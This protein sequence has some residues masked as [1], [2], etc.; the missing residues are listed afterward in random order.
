MLHFIFISDLIIIVLTSYVIALMRMRTLSTRNMS[1]P[2][3]NTTEAQATEAAPTDNKE[4]QANEADTETTSQTPK[5]GRRTFVAPEG[6]P[7]RPVMPDYASLP[8][9]KRAEAKKAYKKELRAWRRSCKK[10]N[11]A[12]EAQAEPVS[13]PVTTTE[14]APEATEP[15][16]VPQAEP[17]KKLTDEEKKARRRERRAARKAAKEAEQASQATP[18][19]PKTEPKT[20]PVTNHSAQEAAPSE[21]EQKEEPKADSPMKKSDYISAIITKM[22]NG[23]HLASNI[24][25]TMGKAA[26]TITGTDIV[27]N[28][29]VFVVSDGKE[30]KEVKAQTVCFSTKTCIEVLNNMAAKDVAPVPTTTDE[31]KDVQ[32]I[33]KDEVEKN[34]VIA[35]LVKTCDNK[36]VEKAV[37]GDG[38]KTELHLKDK[39]SGEFIE[40]VTGIVKDL[41][42]TKEGRI[43]YCV[44]VHVKGNDPLT[45]S[46]ILDHRVVMLP[47]TTLKTMSK[48]VIN[49]FGKDKKSAQAAITFAKA[50]GF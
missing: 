20:E 36:N 50:S 45:Q 37:F 33:S 41:H 31:K 39:K 42:R 30:T 38:I 22:N 15:V 34:D 1:E 2:V 5:T 4:E 9:D 8:E 48:Q 19:A 44:E 3:Q 27:D 7:E 13:A 40:G 29:L 14:A 17:K 47:V 43:A 23:Y 6:A 11:N 25:F 16:N 10:M 46:F 28:V 12:P 35:S 32:P 49:A 26:R 18:E 21:P 24:A